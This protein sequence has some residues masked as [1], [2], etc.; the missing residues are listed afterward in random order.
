MWISLDSDCE[1]M[2]W[3]Q[4]GFRL[5]TDVM[6]L[7]PFLYIHNQESGQTGIRWDSDY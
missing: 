4:L 1:Q 3:D 5:L 7:S 6:I 2:F